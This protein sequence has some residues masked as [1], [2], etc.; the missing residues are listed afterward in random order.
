LISN[1][2]LHR[3]TAEGGGVTAV[4]EDGREIRAD[5]LVGADGIW[6]QVR[7]QMFNERVAGAKGASS[8]ASFTGYK[9]GPYNL[10]SSL[11]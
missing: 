8:T 9:V 3:Y 6:S 11:P 10:N 5:V 4:L 7:A 1:S 2:N